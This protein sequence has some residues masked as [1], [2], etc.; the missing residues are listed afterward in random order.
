VFETRL[1]DTGFDNQKILALYGGTFLPEDE[2]ESW[3][4]APRERLRGK[5]VDALSRYGAT[6]E[7]KGDLP[8]A[9][10]CYMRGIDA[11]PIVES[12]QQGLMRC[13]ERLG[14]RTEA[15]SV[16]R[17]LK[18]T[19][20]VVLGVPPSDAVQRLFQ[21]MLRRQVDEG[22]LVE[23]EVAVL[24]AGS[25]CVPARTTGIVTKLPLRR[26]RSR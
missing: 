16:Y 7:S 12:F 2:G 6:L 3:S 19:L 18:H 8:G 23:P 9:V 17:R 1:A 24:G 22:P 4:V 13:Y 10:R 5:F 14:K 11:D 15:L 20:S 25:A 26:T 21:D